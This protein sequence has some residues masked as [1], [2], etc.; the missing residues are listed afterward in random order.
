LK[1]K[2]SHINKILLL[3]G[4]VCFDFINTV[5]DR[6]N[7]PQFDY[8]TDYTAF[9][10]WSSRIKILSNFEINKLAVY[11]KNNPAETEHILKK[12][13]KQREVLY[14]FF[15]S[16]ANKKEIEKKILFRVNSLI[17]KSICNFKYY[18]IEKELLLL[19]DK[20][21]IHPEKPF[22]AIA[23]SAFDILNDVSFDRIKQCSECGWIFLDAT[24]NNNRRWC[25]MLTCG[26]KNK[27]RRYYR[28][29]IQNKT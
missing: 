19:W 24:K 28:R 23:K 13:K 5:H 15:S 9:L 10:K 26:A 25:N 1:Q 3:G 12:I 22:W 14:K 4:T 7:K 18:K 20:D 21:K 27:S 2:Y 8:L 16:I 17:P 6:Y 29:K 11:S